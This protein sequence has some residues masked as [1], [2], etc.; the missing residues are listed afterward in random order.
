MFR[1][2]D[3][4]KVCPMS[5]EYRKINSD[6]EIDNWLI[7]RVSEEAQIINQG[8]N[9]LQ[10]MRAEQEEL[11]SKKIIPGLEF[12]REDLGNF[13]TTFG[14][15]KDKLLV[16]N[17]PFGEKQP[18]YIGLGRDGFFRLEVDPELPKDS[19]AM[20]WF[21]AQTEGRRRWVI[22]GD[23]F[24]TIN[25]YKREALFLKGVHRPRAYFNIYKS[26]SLT[27]LY[28]KEGI[29]LVVDRI[30][31][32]E[33]N[34]KSTAEDFEDGSHP[35]M[36]KMKDTVRRLEDMSAMLPDSTG[37]NSGLKEVLGRLGRRKKKPNG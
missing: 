33:R 9:E 2:K 19:H 7:P 26:L 32:L 15:R 28:T 25:G 12:R 11:L 10:R 34:I 1:L 14:K 36:V 3:Y 37:G 6:G 23:H 24:V 27:E 20:E 4:D 16:L 35:E 21:R 22:V 31:D 17:E 5:A 30:E 18:Y 29:G 8:V 13:C